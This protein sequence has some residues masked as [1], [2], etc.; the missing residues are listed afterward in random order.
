MFC[1]LCFL[2]YFVNSLKKINYLHYAFER[3][4]YVRTC[5]HT[6]FNLTLGSSTA[7][8]F[9]THTSLHVRVRTYLHKF[10][11]MAHP[12]PH[13]PARVRSNIPMD[14]QTYSILGQRDLLLGHISPPPPPLPHFPAAVQTPRNPLLRPSPP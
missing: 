10:E 12:H 8:P 6:A 2:F 9:H 14:V 5:T 3:I 7:A 4:I 1:V 11:R 13:A